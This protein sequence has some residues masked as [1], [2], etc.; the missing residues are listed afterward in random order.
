[1]QLYPHQITSYDLIRQE[2]FKG[3]KKILFA[4]A[5]GFGKT[6]L[7]KYI[8][9]QAIE[10]NNKVLFTCHR[11][12]LAEQSYEKFSDLGPELLQGTNKPKDASYKC[13]VAT[14]QTLQNTEIE[15]PEIVIID[16][17]HY[18]YEANMIQSLFTRFPKAIFLG[19]SATPVD[20]KGFLLDGWDSFLAPYQTADLIDMGYLTPLQ[21][22][23]NLVFDTSNVKV[24]G[25]DYD[26]ED[27]EKTINKADYNKSIIDTWVTKFNNRKFVL[28]AANSK[29]AKELSAAFHKRGF[30]VPYILA[31]TAKNERD[32]YLD[33]LN[34]G[35]IK[36]IISVEIL[37]AG[38]DEPT[39]DMV[40]L[41]TKTMQWK[42]YI[43]CVGRGIRISAGKIDCVLMDCCG[44]IEQHGLPT[45]RKEF[46]FKTKLGKVLDRQYQLDGTDISDTKKKV[47]TLSEEKQLYLK[48]ISSVLD[49]Y[50]GK[51]YQKE[52]DLLEDI[53][54]FIDKTGYFYYRQNS[55][56]AFIEG[57]WVHFSSIQGLPDLTCYFKN[58][59]IC[60][61]IEVKLPSGTLTKAQRETLPVLIQSNVLFFIA[62][63][64]IDVHHIFEFM[65][66]KVTIV[67]AET[68]IDNSIY[69]LFER[70]IHYR[71]KYL[72]II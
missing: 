40:I 56:K 55:G 24:K 71:K 59:S 72:K 53:K 52:A 25:E 19:M 14:L 57:R 41:A 51:V 27:L 17:V 22:Y 46:K 37:T 63:S 47:T 6:I 43:Q 34:K 21:Y 61:R 66:E 49:L 48:Q 70:Q 30:T 39:I 44:N 68:I 28:F 29:H 32:F 15:A 67:G 3:H 23:T 50:D 7:A 11:I 2:L 31:D 35:E 33:Q 12:Q 45:D 5:T 20:N 18:G 69:N 54:K 36:G 65:Q 64:V 42:K 38:F 10:K 8:I 58:T 16:E 9:Q 26:L 1:M 4:A 62:E 13:L 60:F